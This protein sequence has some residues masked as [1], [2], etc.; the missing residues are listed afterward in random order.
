M[1]WTTRTGIVISVIGGVILVP[2]TS[3]LEARHYGA[4]F[5]AYRRHLCCTVSIAGRNL[6]RK[7]SLL[8][9]IV[10]CYGSAAIILWSYVLLPCVSRLW[11]SARDHLGIRRH[12]H[13]L[14]NH[15]PGALQLGAQM[16]QCQPHR[17]KSS[18]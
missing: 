7:L 5:L 6:R 18:G 15:W 10:L 4:D 1:S 9:Y 14:A 11:V 16:V 3:S 17:R 8:A 13:D 2:E 12:G